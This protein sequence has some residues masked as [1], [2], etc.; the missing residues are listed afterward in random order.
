MDE[1]HLLSSNS[2]EIRRNNIAM[3]GIGTTAAS[4]AASSASSLLLLLLIFATLCESFQFN[5]IGGGLG[6]RRM[7]RIASS[8]TTLVVVVDH[9]VSHDVSRS[10]SSSYDFATVGDF[11]EML[12]TEIRGALRSAEIDLASSGG[13]RVISACDETPGGG[14]TRE[15]ES[16]DLS[17]TTSL[18]S[19]SSSSS[20]DKEDADVAANALLMEAQREADEAVTMLRQAEEEASKWERELAYLERE[21]EIANIVPAV[22]NAGAN[23]SSMVDAYKLALDAANDIVEIVSAQILGLEGE[24][25]DAITKMERSVEERERIDAEY[26]HLA[27]NYGDIKRRYE[28]GGGGGGGAVGSGGDATDAATVRENIDLLNEE[29]ESYQSRISEAGTRLDDMEK[30]LSEAKN[31]AE[32]WRSMHDDV[33]SQ[34]ETPSRAREVERDEEMRTEGESYDL[35]VLE[36]NA[37]VE[38]GRTRPNLPEAVVSRAFEFRHRKSI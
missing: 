26:E 28:G 27:K 29:I 30:P 11:D 33:L 13:G 24:L 8:R 34:M 15:Y 23:L 16:I 5:W 12:D 2:K 32:R 10:S 37:N 36:V 35:R 3:T 18:P 22:N 1:K 14:L 38:E 4:K 9:R 7:Q 20:A 31:E 6:R 17:A 25:E 19:S 21:D